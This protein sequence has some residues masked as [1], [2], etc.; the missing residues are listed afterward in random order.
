MRRTSTKISALNVQIKLPN[1]SQS[2]SMVAGSPSRWEHCFIFHSVTA[3]YWIELAVLEKTL[4]AFEPISLIVPTTKTRMTASITAYSAM[5][6]PASS[7]HKLLK[8]SLT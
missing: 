7:H 1:I 8:R 5:S 6:C 4:L 2:G 3:A